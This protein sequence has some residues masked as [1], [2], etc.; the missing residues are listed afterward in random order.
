M[1]KKFR[2]RAGCRERVGEGG[3]DDDENRWLAG[4]LAG[5]R[6]RTGRRGA[7]T[8]RLPRRVCPSCLQRPCTLSRAAA[9]AAA[10]ISAV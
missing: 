4:W 8:S 6:A 10:V 5:G 9:A 7:D 1:A 2:D 3:A